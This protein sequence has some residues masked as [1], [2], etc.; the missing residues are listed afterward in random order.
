MKEKFIV[1]LIILTIFQFSAC[2]KVTRDN[3]EV[4][5]ELL[6]QQGGRYFLGQDIPQDYIKA[7]ALF[8][9]AAQQG[10]AI[11]QNDLAGM[12]FK[13]LGTAKNEEKAF[14]WYE[15]AAQKNFPEAQYN[16]G[17]MYDHGHYVEKRPK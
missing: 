2:T 6:Y 3:Q 4:Q 8:E 10:S 1:I 9:Q 11:A 5:A 16:L 17:I 12:Y 13:G 7:K 15:R 14:Y